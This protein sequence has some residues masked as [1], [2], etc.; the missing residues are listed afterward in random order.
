MLRSLERRFDQLRYNTTATQRSEPQTT[1]ADQQPATKQGWILKKGGTGLL[2]PWKQKY[3]ILRPR[4]VAPGAALV[5]HVNDK[6]DVSLAPKHEISAGDLRVDIL[7]PTNFTMLPKGAVAFTIT[8]SHR[9]VSDRSC[10]Y[11]V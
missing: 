11:G 8:T 6:R 3:L 5:L 2:A 4:S 9:K 7:P 10:F 1:P